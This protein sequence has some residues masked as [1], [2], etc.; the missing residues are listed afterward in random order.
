LV[1][2]LLKEKQLFIKW[3]PNSA[4]GLFIR[5]LLSLVSALLESSAVLV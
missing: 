5:E 1:N 2:N 3:L 4:D